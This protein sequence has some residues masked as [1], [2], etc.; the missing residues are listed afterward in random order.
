MRNERLVE[1]HKIVRESAEIIAFKA[2]LSTNTHR[3][4]SSAPTRGA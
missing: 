3:N 1:I 2:I 4:K